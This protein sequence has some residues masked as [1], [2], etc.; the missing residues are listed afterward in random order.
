MAENDQNDAAF[1]DL[2]RLVQ[3]D[4]KV[5][6]QDATVDDALTE[7]MAWLSA[8]LGK[9][10][11]PSARYQADREAG[12]DADQWFF[13][14]QAGGVAL[15]LREDGM[16]AYVTGIS[17]RLKM[18]ELEAQLASCNLV[19]VAVPPA[20]EL[21]TAF[22][23]KS[24]ILVAE[25]RPARRA[26]WT[27]YCM[28]GKPDQAVSL[29]TLSLMSL[30]L[31]ALF[32]AEE[33][34][35]EAFQDI[36]VLA[37]APGEVVAKVHKR[38]TDDPSQDVF[39]RGLEGAEA[40]ASKP[41]TDDSVNLEAAE[42]KAARFGYVQVSNNK[43]S[44]LPPFWMDPLAIQVRG[45]ILDERPRQFTMEMVAALFNALGIKEGID[46]EAVGAF[47]SQF[48]SGGHH[49]AAW[50][51]AEGKAPTPGDDGQVEILVDTERHAGVERED[52]SI[53]FKEVNFAPDVQAEQLV[54][55]RTP[56]TRGKAGRK[57]KA[58]VCPAEDGEN[59]ELEAGRNV[60][61]K[62]AEGGIVEFYAKTDGM[63]KYRGKEVW[64]VEILR[65]DGDVGFTTGNLKFSGDIYVKGNVGPG[66]SVKAGG[67]V[68]VGGTVEPG[69][70][71]VSQGDVRIGKGIVG[72]KTRVTALGD[73]R[74]Q[75]VQEA[76]VQTAKNISIGNYAM[77]PFLRAG[78][79]KVLQGE[80][81]RGGSIVGGECWGLR[82]I[83]V[84]FAGN[85]AS[86]KTVLN[87]G[88]D[89]MMAQKLDDLTVHLNESNKQIQRIL[90][91]FGL[92]R[93]DVAQIQNMLAASTGA[94]RKVLANSAR[95][96]G[97]FV[98][99]NQKLV[100]EKKAIETKAS[101]GLKDAK[102]IVRSTIYPGVRIRLGDFQR[103]ITD[104]MTS[105]RFHLNQGE[106]AEA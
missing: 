26:E 21:K 17:A 87:A 79:V 38:E 105:P 25:G 73:I 82:G 102:I 27:E 56:P 77:Q 94:K 83:D 96:L 91:R 71:V 104:E 88:M 101:A 93:L 64:V 6:D 9:P 50:L 61:K 57:V 52:G 43:L 74:T 62:V 39:G 60:V 66:F 106:M 58:Q 14:V 65:V 42:F 80:G 34:N 4:D 30:Q 31:D 24:W 75:F 67:D 32:G 68:V 99:V 89:L 20:E 44:I 48:T 76:T 29:E 41:E 23:E 5:S 84:F 51:L 72:R 45:C 13:R 7:R 63:L 90:D 47:V 40:E 1:E 33:V 98:Q 46:K 10:I 28:P 19:Q 54:A 16:A 8:G 103:V 100:Q 36:R 85:A 95:K 49:G 11:Q 15:A 55:K 92:E 18:S 3:E 12:M 37:A 35:E 81:R 69:A 59:V 22:S 53:D 97:E 2:E 86:T 78:G 70:T